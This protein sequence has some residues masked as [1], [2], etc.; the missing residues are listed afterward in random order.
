MSVPN[1]GHAPYSYYV[2][3]VTIPSGLGT[4]VQASPSNRVL[5][6][7]LNETSTPNSVA[8]VNQTLAANGTF[9][10]TATNLASAPAQGSYNITVALRVVD[11]K[12][13]TASSTKIVTVVIGSL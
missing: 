4:F 9:S 7:N 3:S 6:F 12:G 13:I 1:L 8:E 10:V 11:S 2:D 5:A